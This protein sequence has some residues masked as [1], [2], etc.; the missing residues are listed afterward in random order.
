MHFDHL[1]EYMLLKDTFDTIAVKLRVNFVV[2]AGGGAAAV[3]TK[4]FD[5]K[6]GWVDLAVR[7][8]TW[9]RLKLKYLAGYKKP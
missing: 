9:N 7:I 2:A 3:V 5:T 8:K 6:L 1:F 4:C